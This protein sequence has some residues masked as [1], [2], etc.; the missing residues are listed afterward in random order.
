MGKDRHAIGFAGDDLDEYAVYPDYKTGHEA[1]IVMLKGSKYSPLT[2]SAAM[3]RFDVK[4]PKYIDTVVQ[5][6]ELDPTC[7]IKSLNDHEFELF[8]KSIEQIEKWLVGQED[9]IEKWYISAVR[10]KHG[11]IIEY[12]VLKDNQME[13]I[14]K[15][16][17]IQLAKEQKL[18]AIVVCMKNGTTYLRPE[19]GSKAF[20]PIS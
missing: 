14:L 15:N 10:K 18:H 13:W 5:F 8:W 12:L 4:N 7:T 11:V 6:T 1:L 16:D 19:Y 2:L 3:K 20:K 9:F 17:A